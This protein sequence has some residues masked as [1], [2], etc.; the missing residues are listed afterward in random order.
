[1]TDYVKHLPTA[2]IPE[3]GVAAWGVEDAQRWLRARV[4][5]AFA[6]VAGGWLLGGVVLLAIALSALG[7]AEPGRGE[8]WRGYALGVLL[9]ALPVWFR[10]LPVATLLATPVIAAGAALALPAPDAAGGIGR[11]LVLALAAW[12]FTGSLVRLLARRRQRE[13][14]LA[15]AGSA[16]FP[17]PDPLPA[18]HRRRGRTAIVLGCACCL[19]AAAALT[20]GVLLEVRASGS[21]HPYD[22]G[23]LQVLALVLLV[24]GT[25]VLGRGLA[26]R[27]AA[28]RLNGRPQPALLVGVRISASGHHWIHPDADTPAGPPLIAQRPRARDILTG[29]RILLSGSERTLRTDHHDIDAQA[30]PFEAVVYGAVYEGAEVVLES[31][32]YEG[33]TRLVPYVTA[34]PLLPR[35]R[36]WLR[37]WKPAGRSFREAVREAVRLAEERRRERERQRKESRSSDSAAGGCGGGCGDGGGCGGGCGGCG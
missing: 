18:A 4:P 26:R 16:R 25:T 19:A 2:G 24:P 6:P 23:V 32:V 30:E 5:A 17:L 22:P 31:A 34:A 13:L 21:A 9:I 8:D 20:S 35:R 1:M 28:R 11:G 7:D 3:G 10:H 15:A 37:G 12:A 14:A 29:R 33:G 36:H 27:R